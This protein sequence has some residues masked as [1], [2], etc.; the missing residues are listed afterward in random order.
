MERRGERKYEK[1]IHTMVRETT[2]LKGKRT[3]G[4]K[5]KSLWEDSDMGKM[6]DKEHRKD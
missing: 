3:R 6:D 4:K 5:E 2:H 1:Y